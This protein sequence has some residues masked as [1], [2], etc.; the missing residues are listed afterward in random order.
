MAAFCALVV[1]LGLVKYIF[2]DDKA[3]KNW[4]LQY[5][6]VGAKSQIFSKAR[7]AISSI[8]QSKSWS[9]EGY[10]KYS[11]NNSPFII[12]N[13]ER[14]DVVV[15]PPKQLKEI[16]NL[17]D[18]VLDV[19]WTEMD[20]IQTKYTVGDQDIIRN[21]FHLNVVRAQIPR[22]IKHLTPIIAEELEWGF[23][24]WWGNITE[25]NELRIWDSSLKMI[26]GAANSA[27]CGQPLC[28]N[29]KFLKSLRDH[30]MTMFVG[31]LFINGT[32]RLFRPLTGKFIGWLCEFQFRK[33][34]KLCLPL[35]KERLAAIKKAKADSDLSFD[36]PKDGLQW[37]IDECYEQNNPEQLNPTRIAHR[38]LY[39]NDISLH[40]TSFTIQNVILDIYNAEKSLALVEALRGECAA[41]LEEAGGTWTREAVTKLKLV[42]STIRESMRLTSFASVG[43]PRTVIQ[44]HG[45]PIRS[46]KGIINIPKGTVIAAPLDAIHHDNDI[47]PDSYRFDPYR[48]INP[49][50]VKGLFDNMKDEHPKIDATN[51]A[52]QE[53]KSLAPIQDKSAATLDNTFLG[54]GFGKYACPGRFFA[55]NE[56][57]LFV[58]YMVLNYDVE[59]LDRRPELT[60]VV[61]LKVP[62]NDGRVRV[63]RRS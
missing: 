14:G 38:L 35:I 30:A 2:A 39:I 1:S 44:P 17:P 58:A 23:K 51:Q 26:A 53:T 4:K 28:R 3:A 32:P 10:A 9:F 47:Y 43:L 60:N 18:S 15:I 12:P 22:N 63:R 34:L 48:F 61:W 8:T 27:F 29:E 6:I 55:L 24:R 5:P 41:V 31:A 7:A 36:P 49:D 20:T 33:T 46:S 16:Y 42:D 50:S 37:I 11:K 62:Y 59:C 25:W 56:M 13:I 21:P 57:K 45:I 19:Y 40:S 52:Q 54:F